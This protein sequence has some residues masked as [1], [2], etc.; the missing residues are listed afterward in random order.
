ME[1]KVITDNFEKLNEVVLESLKRRN[2]S[3]KDI[4]V[5]ILIGKWYLRFIESSE[6]QISLK[7]PH[8]NENLKQTV[9]EYLVALDLLIKLYELPPLQSFEG[10]ELFD[11]FSYTHDQDSYTRRRKEYG[12]PFKKAVND[13]YLFGDEIIVS[14]ERFLPVFKKGTVKSHKD[15]IY[16]AFNLFQA[17]V[18]HD[19]INHPV[20]IDLEKDLSFLL[21][22]A[23]FFH[24]TKL[25]VECISS[26][27]I[28]SDD[29]RDE[30]LDEVGKK[31]IKRSLIYRYPY[32]KNVDNVISN[33]ISERGKQFEVDLKTRFSYEEIEKYEIY[34][35]PG[36]EKLIED[37]ES[38]ISL[39]SYEIIDTNHCTQIFRDMAEL[40][41]LWKTTE[42]NIYSTPYPAKWLMC[43]HKGQNLDFWRKQFRKDYP[44]VNG[45][46]LQVVN[47]LID[48]VYELDWMS[49][50]LPKERSAKCFIPGLNIFPKVLD[51]LEDFL[52]NRYDNIYE[53]KYPLPELKPEINNVIILDPFNKITLSNITRDQCL[54]VKVIVPD[55][56][57]FNYQPFMKYILVKYQ[58]G[59]LLEGF[60]SR[61]DIKYYNYSIKWQKVKSDLLNEGK[62][63]LGTYQKK[64]LSKE[65]F[66]LY[67]EENYEQIQDLS[68]LERSE[69]ELFEN[70]QNKERKVKLVKGNIHIITTDSRNFV[71]APGSSI[72]M[73]E[74]G[75]IIKTL[76]ALL[77]PGIKFLPISEVTKMIDRSYI[78]D[79][80]A[81]MPRDAM[82]WKHLLYT[83][84]KRNKSV[85][86]ML[87]KKGLSVSERTFINDYLDSEK[88]VKD[89]KFSL[90]RS[91]ND[92]KVVCNYLG[93]SEVDEAW[94]CHKCKGD[95]NKL[96]KAYS[97]IIQYLSDTANYGVNL[98][99]DVI[100]DVADIFEKATGIIE[101]EPERSR[102][103]KSIINMIIGQLEFM[104]V[105]VLTI[106]EYE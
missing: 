71:L 33:E 69:E 46:I 101:E 77:A 52:L 11:V 97:E 10:T 41:D 56:V 82:R 42:F 30:I 103:A 104:T 62:K 54:G 45:R 1:L 39:P 96:K 80:L 67:S 57:F 66:K 15:A 50:S 100:N 87:S 36:E 53:F 31:L 26:K 19:L 78:L 17:I 61:M 4:D 90:P 6:E 9:I 23:P 84:V 24:H 83:E 85:F 28:N 105:K 18:M 60:R 44:L 22:R 20:L 29:D 35:L 106:K 102:E 12:I 21:M 40:R 51:S 98:D 49:Q 89:L 3:L 63:K 5:L 81:T 37:A 64:Y 75:Y 13:E 99:Q 79:K 16:D 55:F 34:L 88:T 68:D 32:H 58:F 65:E 25:L 92:W 94:R 91:R 47:N 43:I 74:N 93:I 2:D 8:F 59:A 76:A 70:I 48:L 72:L 27:D 95:L 73:V 7:V 86:S 14:K 38:L